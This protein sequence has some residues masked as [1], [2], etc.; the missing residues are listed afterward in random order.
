MTVAVERPARRRHRAWTF[1]RHLLEMLAA[2]FVGMMALYPL[3]LVTGGGDHS[4]EVELLAMATAMTAPMVA[5]MAYRRHRLLP[6]VEMAVAMYAGFLVL[7]PLL[8]VEV[9]DG[10][11]VM[12]LGHVLM[13]LFMLG[14]ML[15]RY[16]EY[17]GHGLP[18]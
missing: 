5:W 15:A 4:T 7:L 1:T 14:A 12:V 6:I 3:W 8:W 9:L 16:R 18:R 10:M 11:D 2:M 13:L 17:A